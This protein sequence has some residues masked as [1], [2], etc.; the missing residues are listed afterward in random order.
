MGPPLSDAEL[1]RL[2]PHLEPWQRHELEQWHRERHHAW[3]Q[4]QEPPGPAEPPWPEQP[5]Q[6]GA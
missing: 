5:P 1:E 3:M 2:Y 4:G 6:E